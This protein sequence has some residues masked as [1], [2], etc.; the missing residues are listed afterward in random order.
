MNPD[1]GPG[2]SLDKI[3]LWEANDRAN[4]WVEDQPL[5]TLYDR[6]LLEEQNATK[7]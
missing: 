2:E 4:I 1:S 6:E 5:L 7:L 3:R